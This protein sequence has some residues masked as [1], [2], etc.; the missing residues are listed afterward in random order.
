MFTAGTDTS[1]STV[2]WALTELIRHPK[3]MAQAQQE[4]DSAV[5]R[6]RAVSDLDLPQLPFLQAV[7]KET[8]RLHP[9]TPLSS[10]A[11]PPRAAKSTATTSLKAPLSWWMYGP[12][13]VT[14]KNGPT[15]L[16]SGPIGSSQAERR[17]TP[18]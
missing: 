18:M 6:D 13:V 12:L 2:E 16:N 8:F 4:L 10:P 15:H 11:W 17:P 3:M 14:Q 5:G 9:P 7:V 1:A